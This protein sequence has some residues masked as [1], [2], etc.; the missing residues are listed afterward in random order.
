LLADGARTVRIMAGVCTGTMLLAHAGVI[1]TRRAS[2]HHAAWDDLVSTG[3]T[4]VKDRV[5]DDGDLMTS[6]GVTC[7]MDPAL[8]LVEREFS[9]SLV[10]GIATP[11]EY[12]REPGRASSQCPVRWTIR[13]DKTLWRRNTLRR[14]PS[15]DSNARYHA[16]RLERPGRIG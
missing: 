1:G 9:R 5:V 15:G 16:P 11:M 4:L 2:T 6:G 7:G 12:P 13:A 8:W 14:A 3:V 10:G